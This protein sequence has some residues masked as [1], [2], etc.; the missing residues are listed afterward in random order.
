MLLSLKIYSNIKGVIDLGSRAVKKKKG[1]E[2]HRFYCV[3]DINNLDQRTNVAKTVQFLKD[4]LQAYIGEGNIVTDLLTHRIIYKTI[5]LS[6]YET[7]KLLQESLDEIDH[8]LPMS[9]SLR[10]DL[11]TLANM[12][13]KPKPPDLNDYLK[14][15]YEDTNDNK[16]AD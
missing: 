10:L 12:A 7:D 9:N 16:N 14:A 11:Q 5:R 3:I 8:Y 15:T 2:K 6:M 1:G 13:G 4:Q